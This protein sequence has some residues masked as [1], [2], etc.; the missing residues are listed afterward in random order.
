MTLRENTMAVLR[1]ENYEKMPLVHFGFWRETLAKWADEGHISREEAKGWADGNPHDF[2][3]GSKLGFD[4]GWNRLMFSKTRIEPPFERKVLEEMDNGMVKFVNPDGVIMI[5]KP[6][7]VSIPME[8]DHLLKNRDDWERD[9]KH[10][11]QYTPDRWTSTLIPKGETALPFNQGGE[12]FLKDDNRELPVGLYS[13]SFIG[14]LRNMVGVENLSYLMIDDMDLLLEML[15]T[16]ADLSYQIVK[17]VLKTGARFDYFHFWEDICFKNGPLV[18]PS[19]LDEHVGPHYKRMTDLAKEY[20]IDIISLDSDG[21]IDHLLPIWFKNGVNTMFPIEV[22]TWRASLTP[23]REQYGK[24]L[25]GVGGMDKVVFSRDF[26]AVD[27]EIER[28]KPIIDLGGFIPC[29]D[30]RI[31]PDAEWDNVRYYCDRMREL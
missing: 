23:W 26:K 15:D 22:G 5:E 13:G 2:S 11:L 4:Y 24:E 18:M 19:F 28:L 29:P 10:R 16:V 1:Y 8:A 12:D 30:H 31:A 14:Y 17:D 6:G 3:I 20:A 7:V 25:R 21:M 9:F 27:E